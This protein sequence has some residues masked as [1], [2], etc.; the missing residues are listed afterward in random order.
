MR[1]GTRLLTTLRKKA[2][3]VGR[4][5]VVSVEVSYG[6]EERRCRVHEK[7]GETVGTEHYQRSI[8]LTN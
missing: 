3:R 2:Q 7:Q 1:R 8:V 4:E 6:G 5:K